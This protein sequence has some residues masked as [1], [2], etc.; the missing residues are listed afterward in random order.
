MAQVLNTNVPSLLAQRNLGKSTDAMAK[1]IHRLSSGFRINSAADD[2][3]G[4]AIADR[5][6]A[7]IRGMD[8]AA[9]NAN[10]GIS[11][12]QVA[13]GAMQET[14]N[15]LQRIREL[16]IQASNGSNST[17]DRQSIQDE[18]SELTKEMDQI[19]NS[20]QFNGQKLLDGSFTN[21]SFQVGA[22]ANQT[23]NFS[24]GS[25][26][27]KSLGGIIAATGTAVT[28]TA[29]STVTIALGNGSATT[30][31]SSAN[32]AGTANGQD[33]TSAYAKAAAIKDANI[34]GLSVTA[35]TSGSA[36][37]GVIGGSAGSTYNLT[38]NNVEIFNNQDVSSALS[39][40]ELLDAINASS[41]ET[42]VVG[43]LVNGQM[44]LTALDGR[45]INI[46]EGGTN[47]VG[48]TNGLSSATG[49]F[50]GD[51]AGT[52]T[53]RGEL[54]VLASES[55]TFGGDYVNL[56]LSS[57]ITSDNLGVNTIDVSTMQGAQ[58]A[59]SRIDAA[60]ASVNSNRATLGSV[61]NRFE[62]TI[63]NLQSVSDSTSAARS[64]IKDTDYAVEMAALTKNQILQQAGTAMLGQANSMPQSVLSL[65]G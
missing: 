26:D 20:T 46:Q 62:S 25:M 11:L 28:S 29:S 32:F 39:N 9:R 30:I 6:T 3:A 34:N 19:A 64:R 49:S 2:A 41:S 27:S 36:V 17:T 5:M 65:L 63:S 15:M 60:L 35:S 24:I 14:T 16:A 61:Q 47:F 57:S 44:T 48:G 1:S 8:Q 7:Q 52:V 31:N 13:E 38:L 23:I 21:A 10:D 58:T 53:V 50:A 12:A 56:G 42:G 54:S 40:S 37:V 45:N 22:N 33:A 4:L 55:V 51:T 43:S 18:I 59:I